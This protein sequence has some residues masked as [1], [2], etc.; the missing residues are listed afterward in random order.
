MH[1]CFRSLL[2]IFAGLASGL[3]WAAP[4]PDSAPPLTLDDAIRLALGQ[5]QNI[6]VSAYT[7]QIASANLLTEYGRFDP[8]LTFSRSAGETET[9]G[10]YTAGN[11]PLT[12]VDDYALTIDGLAP[13]G[14]NYSIGASAENQR[15]SLTNFT[16]NYS[17]F[18]GVTVTQPL[19]RNFGFSANLYG[20]RVAKA[21]R[22]ISEWQYRQTVIDTVTSVIYA[23]N[24][25]QQAHDNLR[26]ARLSRDLAARLLN[27]NEKRRAVGAIADADVTQAKADVANREE[28]ILL[29]ERA[30]RDTENS[31][32]KLIGQSTFDN[33]GPHLAIAGLPP[34]AGVEVDAA[35]GYRHALEL[36]PD[37]RAAEL[38]L[39][40]DRA[41]VRYETNQMLPRVDLVGSY[42]YGGLDPTFGTARAQ[43]RD[44]AARA[45]SAGIVVKVPLTFAAERGRSR[46]AKLTALRAEADLE[47]LKQDIALSVATAAGQIDTTRRRVAATQTAL[48]L[49]KQALDAEE[50]RFKAGT[51]TTYF[52]LR[53]QE[54]LASVE[55][56]HAR[57]LADQRRALATYQRE[58]GTTLERHHINLAANQP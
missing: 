35:E 46:A 20:L 22:S 1:R 38:G 53:Q 47:R 5:N 15:G 33:T 7:P 37:Y 24:N 14:L 4:A 26:I 32:R 52:V 56:S 13:W 39:K 43:V 10:T 41:S 8:A 17:T 58:T 30:L 6:R 21:N 25:L 11:R 45:Y 42:G 12:K 2:L 34:A 19:L 49:A 51:S 50:K 9:P 23:F 44:R 48:E 3:L 29:A 27:E 36:R 31:L 16:D 18:A 28:N 54:L 57:A 40:I 55:N